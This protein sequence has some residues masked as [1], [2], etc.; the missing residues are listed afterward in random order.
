M[1]RRRLGGTSARGAPAGA[2]YDE[3]TSVTP[4]RA[5]IQEARSAGNPARTSCPCGPLV[6]YT[7]RGGS[8]PESVISRIGTASGRLGVPA[9][10]VALREPGNAEAKSDAWG[11]WALMTAPGGSRLLAS[12]FWL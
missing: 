11:T 12:T 2:R 4:P 10:T 6:S 9:G 5:R 8:P 1:V 3:G 7:A